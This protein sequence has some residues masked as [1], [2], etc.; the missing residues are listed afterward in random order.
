MPDVRPNHLRRREFEPLEDR[1][2]LSVSQDA[3]GWSVVT[4]S[5]DSQLIYVSSSLG[6]NSNNGLT[7]SSPVKTFAKAQSLMRNGFPD[8]LLL[9]RGDTFVDYFTNW[10]KSGRSANEPILIGN[11]GTGA[12]PVVD[13]SGQFGGFAT[14]D[15]STVNYLDIIGVEFINQVHN[16]N[17]PTFSFSNQSGVT[18]LEFGCAGGNLLVENC[19]FRY[20]R[21][22]LDIEG[23]HGPL[24][25]ITIRRSLIA[26]SWSNTS[27]H[28]QG[29]Y[30][31]EIDNVAITECVFDHN[32]WN[33]Q[34]TGA[35]AQGYNH[36]IY[37]SSLTT[38]A[39]IENNILS[40]ASFAGVMDR[41]GGI[42]K[43]NVFINDA[44]AVSF[45]NADGANSTAGGVTGEI[46][47]NIVLGD[48]GGVSYGEGIEVGNT[49]PGANVPVQNNII[50]GD[51]IHTAAAIT[52]TMATNT[53]NPSQAV[54]LNDVTLQNN[55]E[56]GWYRGMMIDG[57]FSPGGSG[58][59]ALNNLNIRNNDFIGST[60]RLI[61]QDGR[62]V[63]EQEHWAG[64]RYYTSALSQSS[65]FL[66]ISNVL[67]FK[68]WKSAFDPA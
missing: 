66:L 68:Q 33:E 35:G 32:G 58:L 54:G 4:P 28:S 10:S 12:R 67:S 23:L 65:W 26:D 46:T 64:N 25:N 22:N 63:R 21:N 15:T 41:C 43:N 18:G 7:P 9:R 52:L 42:V 56:Y 8:Q 16:P 14:L 27:A 11:Y 1:L 24:G 34:I 44:I 38:N 40:N 62:F 5:A 53:L 61:R 3:N 20:Y 50:V 31:N 29:M 36:N 49:K 57:R 59:Y 51:T 6:N 13:T 60:N 47:G 37:L 2:L 48:K 55:I 39:D 45:G 30:G 19:S 17:S